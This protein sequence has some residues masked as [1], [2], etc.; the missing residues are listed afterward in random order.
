MEKV[1]RLGRAKE[2]NVFC[3]I[4]WD[5][6]RLSITGVVGPMRNGDCKGSC[7]QIGGTKIEEFPEPWTPELVQQFY[8]VWERWHLNDMRA[9]CEHQRFEKW[10]ER[11]IDPSKPTNAYGKFYPGQECDSWNMLTWVRCDE[12]K[13]GLMCKPCAVCGY[14]YGTQW[15]HEEVPE[16]V[17]EFLTSLP[18]TDMKPAWV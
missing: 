9:G 13:D 3:N 17:I 7:G 14:K 2:G 8:E 16:K 4:K 12:Y 15:L 18:D 6:K 11:P 10:D 5:G 1:V